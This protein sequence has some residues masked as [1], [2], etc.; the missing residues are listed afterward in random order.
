MENANPYASPAGL[1]YDPGKVSWGQFLAAAGATLLCAGLLAFL[2]AVIFEAGFYFIMLTPAIAA[3]LLSGLL[4]WSIRV[5]HCRSRP[6]AALIGVSGALM[7]YFGQY[8]FDMVMHVGPEAIHRLDMLPRFIA[9]RKTVETQAG[10]GD[11]GRAAAKPQRGQVFLNWLYSGL[12]LAMVFFLA[13]GAAVAAAGRPYCCRCRKWMRR[14]A[15][16][17]PAGLAPSL[18]QAVRNDTLGNLLG[19]ASSGPGASR[20]YTAV[21]ASWC[22]QVDRQ[23][24]QCPAYV[25]VK[26]VS[27]GGGVGQLNQIDLALGRTW[28]R[29]H[30]LSER[31]IAELRL[32]FPAMANA[33]VGTKKTAP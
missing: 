10:P 6:L 8:H 25:S 17:L 21:T 30:P 33:A 24:C 22:P 19:A 11:A 20:R 7:L 2:L 26:A 28:L 4:F 18:A 9:W 3:L 27:Y 15:R 16:F 5:G 29:M 31:Q 13:A 1:E 14:E 32:Q 12:E 23:P